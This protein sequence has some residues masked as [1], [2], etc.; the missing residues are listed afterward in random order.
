M[1]MK[2]RLPRWKKNIRSL[3]VKTGH[4]AECLLENGKEA[5]EN[6]T[7]KNFIIFSTLHERFHPECSRTAGSCK[8]LSQ[9]IYE[10]HALLVSLFLLY[11]N[12]LASAS[13]TSHD[14]VWEHHSAGQKYR[15]DAHDKGRSNRVRTAVG[16][17]CRRPTCFICRGPKYVCLG[18]SCSSERFYCHDWQSS[19]RLYQNKQLFT[20]TE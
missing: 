11:T 5:G 12:L 14:V 19:W 3:G 2:L 16:Q 10:L 1:I 7:L 20:E 18:V 13:T 6:C 17:N 4:W 15:A 8:P 9:C